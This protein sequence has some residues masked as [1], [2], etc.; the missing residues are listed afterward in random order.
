V[1]PGR[2]KG[3]Q[4]SLPD[5]NSAGRDERCDPSGREQAGPGRN[6]Q[7]YCAPRATLPCHC[8]PATELKAASEEQ[9]QEALLRACHQVLR[10]STRKST[11]QSRSRPETICPG[12]EASQTCDA[13]EH[14]PEPME[15]MSAVA[16]TQPVPATLRALIG[17]LAATDDTVSRT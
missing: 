8:I 11:V 2:Q 14:T 6:M 15:G 4:A 5:T 13:E 1:R 17:H 9:Q 7:V 3:C 10:S 12:A 16:S